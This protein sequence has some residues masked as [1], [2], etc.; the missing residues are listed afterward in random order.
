MNYQNENAATGRQILPDLT[1]AY[2]LFGIALVNVAAL[3]WPAMTAYYGGG[4]ETGLDKGAYFLVNALFLLKAYTLFSFMFGVGFAYQIRSAERRGTA[5]AGQYWRRI[6]GLLILGVLHVALLFQGDIL[7][8][9]AILGSILFLFR[10]ASERNLVRWAIGIY[11][12]QV[13]VMGGMAGIVWLGYEYA[14]EELAAAVRETQ[15]SDELAFAVFG[16]GTFAE[17]VALRIE[18]WTQILPYSLLMQGFGAF[19][20]FLFGLA[21][22]RH[23]AIANPSDPIWRRARRLYLPVGLA[24]SIAG[25]W[26]ILGADDFLDPAL[27]FGMFLITLFSP[28]ASAGYI[29]LMARWAEGPAG[30]VKTFF[31]RGGTATLTAYLLQSLLFSVVFNGYGLGLFGEVGAAGSIAIAFLI[32]FISIVFCSLW[33]TRFSRGPMEALL[34]GWTYLGAR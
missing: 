12:V 19:S 9:Y 24:G 30:P 3:S 23:G 5:F 2:A 26:V 13:L 16:G 1:R 27:V 18:E 8:M 11:V 14:P 20:F 31:A 32:A 21:A 17:T 33:R 28:F 6:L 4:L 25:A 10:R 34:R 15:Q 22:V 7:I 29:G